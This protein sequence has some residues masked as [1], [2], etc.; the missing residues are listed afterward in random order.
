MGISVSKNFVRILR[1]AESLSDAPKHGYTKSEI[2]GRTRLP[3]STVYRLLSDME[4][5]GY[6][7]RTS[8]GRL[9]PNFSFDR[10]IVA[11]SIAPEKL[12]TACSEV[13]EQ[14]E[15]A[16]EIILRRGHNLLWHI[17]DEHPSQ[18]IRLR[19]HPGYVRATYEL[20][21]VSRLALAYCRID[22]IEQSWDLSSFY[23]V[24]V[25]GRRVTWEDARER[26]LLTD[27][28]AMQFDM[29]GNAKGVRRYCVAITNANDELICVL[30]AVEAAT[31]VRDEQTHVDHI[32]T[33]LEEAR[34]SVH[35]ESLT[36]DGHEGYELREPLASVQPQLPDEAAI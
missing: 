33:I 34:S 8:Q 6:I 30:S 21:S 19:A 23:E 9:L 28:N 1:L 18:R 7:Y 2:V 3:T 22:E 35:A 25:E 20:D 10:R 13:S 14:L 36:A 15:T 27:R 24:G 12:R 4:E 16:S 5:A 31:P 29:L 32:R 26:I 11:G 17:T